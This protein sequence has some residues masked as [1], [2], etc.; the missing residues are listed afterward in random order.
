[1]RSQSR[2]LL[3]DAAAA[4]PCVPV[5]DLPESCGY[6][7]VRTNPSPDAC[8]HCSCACVCAPTLSAKA[9]SSIQGQGSL[10]TVCGALKKRQR[11][12]SKDRH[13]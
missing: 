2:R 8:V 9:L 6:L 5:A 4:A 3:T 13:W 1:M 10:A 7:P 11:F 12:K